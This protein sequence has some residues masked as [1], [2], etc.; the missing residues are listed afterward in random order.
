VANYGNP[1]YSKAGGA[2]DALAARTVSTVASSLVP[3]A[4]TI[5]FG[6]TPVYAA[7]SLF[8]DLDVSSTSTILVV[9]QDGD[10]HEMD[11]IAYSTVAGT[12]TFTIYA[13]ST[14]GP[15]AGSRYFSY[16]VL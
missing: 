5:D 12:E 13:R 15:V 9:P 10:E 4:A 11:A 2:R 1:D 6:S 14:V 3:V 16:V 7:S 8:G